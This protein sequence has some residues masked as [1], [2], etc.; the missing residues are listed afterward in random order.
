MKN[1]LFK[2]AF[3]ASSCLTVSCGLFGETNSQHNFRNSKWGM[4]V[5]EVKEVETAD[6]IRENVGENQN[7][8]L[9][10]YGNFQMYDEDVQAIYVFWTKDKKLGKGVYNFENGLGTKK[11]KNILCDLVEKYFDQNNYNTLNSVSMYG[12]SKDEVKN[13]ININDYNVIVDN[14]F[15]VSFSLDNVFIYMSSSIVENDSTKAYVTISYESAKYDKYTGS[16]QL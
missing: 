4:S 14:D 6:L 5:D 8:D 2:L 10:Y 16:D 1:I 3:V 11:I 15:L 7:T 12:K 13:M 9:L